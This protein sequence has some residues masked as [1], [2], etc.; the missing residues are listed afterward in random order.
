MRKKVFMGGN[1]YKQWVKRS[2]KM[3]QVLL[4]I[5]MVGLD[6]RWHSPLGTI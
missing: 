6:R 3:S 4:G 1:L 5:Y 2:R